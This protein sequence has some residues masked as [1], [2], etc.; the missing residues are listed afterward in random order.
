MLNPHRGIVPC[1]IALLACGAAVAA[2]CSGSKKATPTPAAETPA[3]TEASLSASSASPTPV[4]PSAA[5]TRP[6][7]DPKLGERLQY[8]GDIE[9]AAQ[10]YARIAGESKGEKQQEAR[11]TQA[12]LLGRASRPAEARPVLETYVAAAG[13]ASDAST[14]RFMLAS[15][16][17][18]LGDQ[19]GA[20]AGYDRYIAARGTLTDFAQIER[21]KLLARLGRGA[22]AET[23]ATAVLANPNL[24][25]GFTRSFVLSMGRAYEQAHD[26]ADA[27][28]WYDGAKT[29]S[30]DPASAGARAGAVRKRLGD[31]AWT[32]DYLAVINGYP[33]SP[34]APDL[35]D[36]LAAASV[37]MSDYA[38]GVVD[39]RAFRNDAAR[40]ALLRAIAAGDHA[41]ESAYYV[42]ALDER[43]GDNE[44]AIAD[45]QRSYQLDPQSPLSDDALWWRAR[46]LEG[47]GRLDEAAL[48]YGTLVADHLQSRWRSDAEFR[49]GLVLY[50]GAKYADAALAWS[51]IVPNATGDDV[52]RARFWQ[53]RALTA[54]KDPL[55]TA[56][57]EQ[58][59]SD[60]EARDT[61]YALRAEVLLGRNIGGERALK[62]TD[63]A[64]DW[65]KIAAYVT[66]ATG[67]DPATSA[68]QQAAVDGDPRWAVGDALE[69]VGLRA[70]SSAVFQ[71]L[72]VARSQSNA[73]RLFRI[74]QR[75]QQA[76]HTSLAAR[77][78]TTLIASLPKNAGTPD[79]LLRIAYPR[80]Y[81]DLVTASAK[82]EAI[83][84]LLLLSLVRQESYYDADAGSGAGALGLTQVVP[85][86]GASIADR[87]GVAGF[88]AKDLFRPKLSLQFGANY[89]ASQLK[90]FDNNAYHA[91][92]AYN[93]GPGTA[94]NAIAAAG[95]DDDLFVEELEFDETKS[96]V[97]LVMQN[98]A[99]YRQLYE[100]I[101]RSSLPR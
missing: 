25:P 88:V 6:A 91:L 97:K 40:I 7:A 37:P 27:L 57:L 49:H 51:V 64:P 28:R 70:Q 77:A 11:L 48:V 47:A 85:G 45:Y 65:A 76:G 66:T 24:L 78:A 46:L 44:A 22:E 72:I 90:S 42:A 41:A 43:A 8:E 79:D 96:Y 101:A 16:L 52:W 81:S 83:S 19:A 34:V 98:Y 39:Y 10:V 73:V 1:L 99:R 63:D 87:L 75:F 3:A 71:S 36:E 61:F 2:A 21:A 60:P 38:R 95:D 15:T 84:P 93:G 32:A 53:G 59:I 33:S 18:D 80:A 94:S 74:T 30:G 9:G 54:Q 69:A 17:D 50:K 35:L 4:P 5:P 62:R 82:K 58:L 67:G 14:A 13:T 56:V 12:Q 23:A 26:D 68:P 89:L 86:T 20:L 29:E 100:G 55:G 31:P 92:A